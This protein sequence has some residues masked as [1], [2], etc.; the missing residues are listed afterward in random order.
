MIVMKFGG[1]SLAD[2]NRIRQVGS[3]VIKNATERPV[4]VLSAMGDTTNL[5]LEAGAKAI[6]QTVDLSAIE[7][8]YLPTLNELKLNR[9]PIDAL[10]SDLKKLLEKI[11]LQKAC[12]L[13]DRDYLVSFGERMTVRIFTDYLNRI[14]VESRSYDGWEI[15]M[16]T[17]S[18]FGHA[19]IQPETYTNIQ[20]FFAPMEEKYGFVPVVTGFIAHDDK[21][22]IT[23]LGRGGS[24]LTATVIGCSIQAKEIQF[25]KDVSGVLT[26]N[27]E[28]I[29]NAKPVGKISFEE[30]AEIASLGIQVFH[31]G[32]M[33]PVIQRS[34]PVRVKN[35]YDPEAIGTLINH[36]D[37]AG[38]ESIKVINLK[39]GMTLVEI[40]SKTTEALTGLEQEPKM[41]LSRVI[42]WFQ[43]Q[44]VKIS[45]LNTTDTHV[46]FAVDAGEFPAD[47]LKAHL[48]EVADVLV[49][50]KQTILSIIGK[51]AY[52]TDV[53]A[54]VS[55]VLEDNA[56]QNEK[57]PFGNA[58]V[59]LSFMLDERH[60]EKAYQ[61]L[62]DRFFS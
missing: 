20:N 58:N 33:L 11:K 10:L 50:D 42:D 34:I 3:I 27:P 41:L 29:K 15:G 44:Q 23:T 55:K 1:S 48:N 36:H 8:V 51:L 62:H 35:S 25:W 32:S 39:N 47:L 6:S 56:I 37:E 60:S 59:N 57:I 30:A 7:D 61:L 21:G 2:A 28:Y 4:L 19:K 26:A 52:P 49:R 14:G 38:S 54:H 45:I 12:P 43:I 9:A 53:L 24:D 46:C 22:E 13:Q 5:L 31:P 16:K 17:D 18:H 40:N